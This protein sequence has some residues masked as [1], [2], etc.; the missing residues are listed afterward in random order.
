LDFISTVNAFP[1]R[2]TF[3]LVLSFTFLTYLQERMIMS[4][5]ETREQIPSGVK[6]MA[7]MACLWVLI[8]YS[9]G[10]TQGVD[11][12]VATN[13]NDA[14]S[15]K[16]ENPNPEGTDGPFATLQRANESW[17]IGILW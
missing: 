4:R 8:M 9:A 6:S 16:L 14:W 13:G 2:F 10:T 5:R 11:F 3:D 1:R 17:W 7:L 12:I 15:G